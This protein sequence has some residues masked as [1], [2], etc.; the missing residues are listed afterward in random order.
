MSNQLL[1]LF[2]LAFQSCESHR[3]TIDA[4]SVRRAGDEKIGW[5]SCST[6]RCV[7]SDMENHLYLSKE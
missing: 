1:Y 2:D 4:I 3:E 6:E 5:H 7:G